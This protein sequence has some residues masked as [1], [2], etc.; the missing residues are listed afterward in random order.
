MVFVVPEEW[1]DVSVK[2]EQC[3]ESENQVQLVLNLSG[4]PSGVS[5]CGYLSRKE[6]QKMLMVRNR[7]GHERLYWDDIRWAE[8]RSS[9]CMVH[10]ADGHE[11]LV[12]FPLA[13]LE[14]ALPKELFVRIQRSFLVNLNYVEG[15]RGNA[16]VLGE[17]LLNIGRAYRKEVMERVFF[18][19]TKKYEK[20]RIQ[21]N[22][23]EDGRT[24][25][26]GDVTLQR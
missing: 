13:C 16:F 18:L 1:Q 11:L 25:T 8:A 5:I 19:G 26:G 2:I 20:R 24:G 23:S 3:R 17:D 14:Q 12:S 7:Q 10:R 9:Y 6:E 15:M 22:M 21:T 4:I